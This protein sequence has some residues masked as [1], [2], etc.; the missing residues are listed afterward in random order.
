ML[1]PELES[2]IN[3]LWAAFWA[4]GLS[5]PLT[6]IEQISYLVFMKRLDELDREHELSADERN[7][8][9]KSVFAGRENC[10][11]SCWKDLA[12]EAMFEH[13]SKVVFPFVKNLRNGSDVLYSQY[14]RDAAFVIP[15]PSLLKKAVII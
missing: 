2:K 11:W 7:Q 10:R 13:V 12:P 1:D 6:G 9:Y 8:K 3:A 4:E 14:M 5:N 15:T